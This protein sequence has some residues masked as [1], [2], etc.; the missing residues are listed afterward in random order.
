MDGRGRPAAHRE[1][2][3]R[4]RVP[5]R[6]GRVPQAR[7]HG[8]DRRRWLDARVA[9]LPHEG[10]H[11]HGARDVQQQ[12]VPLQQ[13]RVHAVDG[14]G[15]DRAVHGQ[16]RGGREGRG[17]RRHARV[18]SGRHDVRQRPREGHL[19]PRRRPR[20]DH[21]ASA[22]GDEDADQGR[23]LLGCRVPRRGRPDA[24]RGVHAPL[25]GGSP[26]PQ[27]PRVRRY[28]R[29]RHGREDLPVGRA[30]VLEPERPRDR[31]RG[32]HAP[33]DRALSTGH[34]LELRVVGPGRRV[35]RGRVL[36][37]R[38]DRRRRR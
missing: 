29:R 24:R 21:G 38:A 3:R 10:P 12:D 1:R 5:G 35:P 30:V 4:G 8:R 32:E 17:E 19:L 7:G 33:D 15:C 22:R 6:G 27:E 9:E 36:P 34:L 14:Q 13:R 2:A 31:P 37:A 26:R 20:L 25:P 23:Q 11:A 16:G 28:D 18:P